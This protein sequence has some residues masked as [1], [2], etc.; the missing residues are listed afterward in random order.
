MTISARTGKF[1]LNG[2]QGSEETLSSF[3]LCFRMLAGDS[4][5]IITTSGSVSDPCWP[6]LAI[7]IIA[8]L[9]IV[10]VKSR[11]RSTLDN[12]PK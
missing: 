7:V 4:E 8:S 1:A 9:E 11:A 6:E 5:T 12:V 2:D 3:R 10:W